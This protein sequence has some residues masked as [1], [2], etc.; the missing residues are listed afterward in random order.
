MKRL[1]AGSNVKPSDWPW[2]AG[3]VV[4]NHFTCGGVLVNEDYVMT[5]AHCLHRRDELLNIKNIKVILGKNNKFYSL[6]S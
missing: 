6:L 1:V 4:D 2:M 3:I 5:A